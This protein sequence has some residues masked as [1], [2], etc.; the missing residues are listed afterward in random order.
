MGNA[1]KPANPKNAE[2]RNVSPGRVSVTMPDGRKIS[3]GPGESAKL[4]VP[5]SKLEAFELSE[6]E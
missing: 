6:K 3:V 1:K 5:F 4:P 2:M